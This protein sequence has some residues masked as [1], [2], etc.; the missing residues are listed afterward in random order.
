MTEPEVRPA[1]FCNHQA[2]RQT[3][4]SALSVHMSFIRKEGA[5]K[6]MLLYDIEKKL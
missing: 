3:C 1:Q 4:G 6:H 5:S 2:A